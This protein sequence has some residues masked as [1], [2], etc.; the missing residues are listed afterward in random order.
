MPATVCRSPLNLSCKVETALTDFWE[1]E[2]HSKSPCLEDEEVLTMCDEV[3]G[4]TA[5]N[6]ALTAHATRHCCYCLP[7]SSGFVLLS[8]GRRANLIVCMY[9]VSSPGAHMRACPRTA[10]ALCTA[11]AACILCN[12]PRRMRPCT[13]K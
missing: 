4:R 6:L 3:S 2:K 9:N 12:V 13:S 7:V 8:P 10:A 1:N 5:S 11:C